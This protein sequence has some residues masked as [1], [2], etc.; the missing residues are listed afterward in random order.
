MI[1]HLR[2]RSRCVIFLWLRKFTRFSKRRRLTF[3]NVLFWCAAA[4]CLT[5][6]SLQ[7]HQSIMSWDAWGTSVR[8]PPTQQDITCF[9][10]QGIQAWCKGKKKKWNMQKIQ[11]IFFLSPT[12]DTDEHGYSFY[13]ARIMRM[14]TD[15]LF[16][17]HGLRGWTQ[18]FFLP[19]TD[20]ADEHGFSFCR[21]RMKQILTDDFY[22]TK[23]KKTTYSL[24]LCE[25]YNMRI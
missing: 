1:I 23:T 2:G 21:T 8:L 3:V 11:Q 16:S 22:I 20:I 14:N 25:H 17:E 5:R 10:R 12:D 19:N 7:Q 24:M 13:R 6:R 9:T 4:V 15:F 18:I